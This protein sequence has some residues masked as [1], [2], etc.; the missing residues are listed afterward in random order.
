[1]TSSLSQSIF[2]VRVYFLAPL[3]PR[4]VH[5]RAP[6]RVCAKEIIISRPFEHRLEDA[7]F[8]FRDLC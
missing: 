2:R 1:M 3:S 8:S 6:S 5:R 7:R 4:C